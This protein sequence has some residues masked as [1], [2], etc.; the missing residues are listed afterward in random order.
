MITLSITLPEETAA[1]FAEAAKR[2]NEE[3]LPARARVTPSMLMALALC[4]TK[5]T[6]LCERYELGLRV[7][8]REASLPIPVL[9]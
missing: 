1:E 7:I 3:L 8:A 5:S 2:I 9:S 6:E 4:G